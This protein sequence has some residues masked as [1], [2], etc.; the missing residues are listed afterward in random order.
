MPTVAGLGFR[1]DVHGGEDD[2][3]NDEGSVGAA[4]FD[5]AA[6]SVGSDGAGVSDKAARSAG[7]DGAGIRRT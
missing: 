5:E 4:K 6:G 1:K 3:A 7:S 2:E